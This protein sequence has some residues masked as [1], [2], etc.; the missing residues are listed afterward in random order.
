MKQESQLLSYFTTEKGNEFMNNSETDAIKDMIRKYNE[1]RPKLTIL[2]MGPGKDNKDD[3]AHKCYEKR[4]QVRDS[5]AEKRHI[6]LFPEVAYEEAKTEGDDVRS[7]IAFEKSLVDQSH[8]V[9]ILLPPEAEGVKS[10]VD[11][12]SVIPQ[13]ASKIYLFYDHN[14]PQWHL[15]DSIGSIEGSGGKTDKFCKD[16]IESCSLLTKIGVKIEQIA[17]VISMAPHKKYQGIA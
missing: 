17:S 4:C 6:A 14:Y 15:N 5:L 1:S 3:Y 11:K 16:D 8:Q 2:V 7:I 13:C 10:E 12:F 9:I